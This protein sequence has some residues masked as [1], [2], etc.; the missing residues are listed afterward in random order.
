MWDMHDT[1]WGWWVLMSIGMVVFWVG[2]IYLVVWLAR[3]AP[4]GRRADQEEPANETPLDLLGRRLAEGEISV[5][6]YNER[7]QALEQGPAPPSAPDRV[8]APAP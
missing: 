8:S 4:P 1:G 5:D 7:R 2:V 6:E 3:G